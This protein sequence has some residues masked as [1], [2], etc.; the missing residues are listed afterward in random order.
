MNASGKQSDWVVLQG[1]CIERMR[2][3][4]QWVTVH[5]FAGGRLPLPLDR[6]LSEVEAAGIEIDRCRALVRVPSDWEPRSE[7]AGRA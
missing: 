4:E 6:Y 7:V 1:D 3:P 2:D 5:L